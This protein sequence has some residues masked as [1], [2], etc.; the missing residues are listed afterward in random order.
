MNKEKNVLIGFTY[1]EAEKKGPL[2]SILATENLQYFLENAIYCNKNYT[3]C[4]NINGPYK[5]D[6]KPFLNK[7]NNL[8]II[9]GNGTCIIDAYK[10][11]LDNNNLDNYDYF[12]FLCDKIRGPYNLKKINCDWVKYYINNLDKYDFIINQYGTSPM[13]KLFKMPYIPFKFSAFNKKILNLLNKD[14]FFIKNKYNDHDHDFH[15]NPFNQAEIK[16]SYFLL[17]NNI[18]YV[19]LDINGIYDLNL[20]RIYKKKNWNKLFE[21]TKNVHKVN[22]KTIINKIFWTGD[23]MIKVFEQKNKKYIKSLLRDREVENLEKW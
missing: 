17:D 13:G 9:E 11:I 1:Y 6:F 2:P 15:N 14:N 21:I 3:Y 20:V 18:N 10:N 5:F 7:Y 19:V 23:T 4:I 16:L 8:K 12:I 22:N